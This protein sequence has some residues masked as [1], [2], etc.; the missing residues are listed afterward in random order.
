MSIITLKPPQPAPPVD[1]VS[2]RQFKLQLLADGIYDQVAAFV[3]AQPLAVQIAYENSATF[4]R[5]DPMMAAGFVA[6]GKDEAD[7]ASFF[8]SASQI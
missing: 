4:Q 6:L 7:V 8:E 5:D 1:R 3:A 2:S